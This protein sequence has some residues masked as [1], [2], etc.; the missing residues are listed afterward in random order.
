MALRQRSMKRDVRDFTEIQKVVT[1][2]VE[3]YGHLDLIF[4]NNA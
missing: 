1:E 3:S 2:T 4:T